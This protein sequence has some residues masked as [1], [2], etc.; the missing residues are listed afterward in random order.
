MQC[1]L[2][3][4]LVAQAVLLSAVSQVYRTESNRFVEA[5]LAWLE[6]AEKD[7]AGLRAPIGILL[8]S[9]KSALISVLDGYVPGHVQPGRNLRKIMKAAA[10][11][12][13]ERISREIFSK[14]EHIDQELGQ[15]NEKMCH[16]VAVLLSK[17]PEIVPQLDPAQPGIDKVWR[18]LGATPETASMYHYFS[19]KLAVS[20]RNYLL[21]DILQ[22]IVAN[23]VPA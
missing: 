20:D 7:L 21:G 12:S 17:S 1:I 8:Q 2:R 23:R 13:L 6:A 11:Q 14:V 9:E 18:M 15:Q 10:A 19:A 4:K 16:A 22:K 3:E 5:Y